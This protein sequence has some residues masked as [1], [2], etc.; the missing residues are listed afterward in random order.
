MQFCRE[1]VIFEGFAKV[2]FCLQLFVEF[3]SAL[4]KTYVFFYKILVYQM[5]LYAKLCFYVARLLRNSQFACC[6]LSTI[7]SEQLSLS[8]H[9]PYHYHYYYFIK[10]LLSALFH[11]GENF[12]SIIQCQ[13][14][15]LFNLPA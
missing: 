2:S 7:M 5:K 9:C 15:Q 11:T 10:V 12:S 14:T 4:F 3:R 13:I 6:L 8:N 1:F